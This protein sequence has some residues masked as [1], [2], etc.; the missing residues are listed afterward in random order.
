[1]TGS[2]AFPRLCGVL[3]ALTAGALAAVPASAQAPVPAIT[4]PIDGQA[5]QGQVRVTGVTDVPGFASAEVDFGYD[6]DP[7]DAW[8]TIQTAS[9]PVSGDLLATWD[10]T[11]ITDGDYILRLRVTLQ[12]GS[13]Q[14]AFAKVRVRNYTPTITPSP[15][16]TP[17]A[18]PRLE[19][20]T[21]IILPTTASATAEVLPLAPT[22][23]QLPPNPAGLAP[24]EVFSRFGRGALVVGLLV[25]GFGALVRLRR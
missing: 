20:P 5:V 10:T 12:D 1:M 9:L 22:P 23:T 17:T 8:F 2:G 7:T 6:P 13:Y 21:P 4:S 16:I 11:A 15:A 18:T 14:D 19:V 25:L 24:G 3:A